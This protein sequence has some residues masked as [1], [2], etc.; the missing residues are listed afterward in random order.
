[1]ADFDVTYLYMDTAQL[2]K[3]GLG[4]R[5]AVTES[6]GTLIK[7]GHL[8]HIVVLPPIIVS[9]NEHSKLVELKKGYL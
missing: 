2:L 1:M 7:N 6:P 8:L 3:A 9:T 4:G 5:L